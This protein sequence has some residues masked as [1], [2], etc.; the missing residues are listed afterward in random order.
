VIGLIDFKLKDAEINVEQEREGNDGQDSGD[1][2]EQDSD[3]E[4]DEEI[5]R[6]DG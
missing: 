1:F 6:G 5:R 3:Y 2:D 4:V